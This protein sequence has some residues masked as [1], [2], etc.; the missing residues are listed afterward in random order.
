MSTEARRVVVIGLD[1]AEP[2]LVLERWRS[3]L[4]TLNR[5]MSQGAFGRLESCHPPITVPAWASML[6]SRDPGQLGYYG[7]R[8][9]ADYSYGK[10]TIANGTAVQFPRVWDVLS[11]AHKPSVVVGV[12][13]TYPVRPLAGNLI[14][15]FLTPPNAAQWTYPAELAAEVTRILEG[16]SYEF[17]VKNFRTD[18]RAWLLEAI[19]QMTR[20]RWRVLQELIRTK[21]WDLFLCVEMGTDRIH[22]GFWSAMDPQHFRYVAG[23]PFEEA[24]HDYYVYLD[25]QIGELLEQVD[26]DTVVLVVSDHGAQ[27]MEGGFCVNQWLQEQ[28]WLTLTNQPAGIVP[29][30]QCAVDWSQTMAWGDGG[31]YGRIFLNV[32]G[33]EPEGIIPADDYGAVRERL[34]AQLEAT[35]GPDGQRLGTV[36]LKPEEVYR[37]VGGVAPDLI[38]YFGNLDWRSVGS[39]GHP[40]LYTYDNDTGPDDAN[41]AQNGLVIVWDPRTPLHGTELKGLQLECI[42][43][44]VLKLLGVEV[45]PSMMGTPIELPVGGASG[46][47]GNG[48]SGEVRAGGADGSGYTAEEEDLITQHL[49]AL[50]YVE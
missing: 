19:Y 12:P 44:T 47:G 23:N 8:N 14:S 11:A 45:P 24:I 7:F 3:D 41:H 22:H 43:P 20:K 33:R 25:G 9:R 30:S 26:E 17:D 31:Y 15:C 39:V 34:K 6:A 2:S 48:T 46:G 5:L 4:P 18:D 10:L 21:P 28:G 49:A 32:A 50:G 38:V 37:E 40:S 13:Q 35:Q 36:V 29:L 1:C 16:E 27:R 42:G